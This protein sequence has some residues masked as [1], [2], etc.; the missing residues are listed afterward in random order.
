M[1]ST[2]KFTVLHCETQANVAHPR[3]I[4]ELSLHWSSQRRANDAPRFCLPGNA[5]LNLH[6]S[7]CSFVCPH[8]DE[9]A[10]IA[11]LRYLYDMR[12]INI[13]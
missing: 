3:T 4:R 7:S 6:G 9:A 2:V 10:V 11:Q 8:L 13:K 1:Y 5:L 12:P